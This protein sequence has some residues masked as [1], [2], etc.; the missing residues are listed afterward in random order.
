MSSINLTSDLSDLIIVANAGNSSFIVETGTIPALFVNSNTNIGINTVT[1][2]AQLEVANASGSCLRL[3]HK[4]LTGAHADMSISNSG[5]L[6]IAP[7]TTGSK[8]SITKSLDITNHNGSTTGL[9][10]GGVLLSATAEQI[11]AVNS[12][13]GTA[14][15]SKVV[16]LDSST[17]IAGINSLS[18][19]S[20]GGT[21]TTATQPNITS[22]GT[23]ASLT[24]SGGVSASTLT[25]TLQTSAQP[26]ITSIGTLSSL[27][28]SGSV[29]AS[30][31]TGT[32][33]TGAQPNIT[34]LGDLSSLT[35][36]GA[37]VD[38][39]FAF[40]SGSVAG[41]ASENHVLVIDAD[42][43][44]T[45]IGAL[46]ATSLT[47]TL[48]TAA[49]PHA[50]SL[51][52]LSSLTVSGGITASSL[53]GSIQTAAQP[54]ITSLGDLVSLT[55]A[56]SSVSPE[57]SYLAGVTPGTAGP[58]KVVVLDGDKSIS[59]L[60]TL[61]ATTL[62][63]TI[64]TAA[65]PNI[66]SLG[67]LSQIHIAGSTIG[68]E[69]S[70]LAGVVA[71]TAEA[72]KV[73]VLNSGGSI[74]GITSLTSTNIYGTIQT[75]DQSSVTKV[76]TLTSLTVNG[77]TSITATA[78]SSSAGTGALTITGGVGIAKKLYVGDAIYGTLATAAQT[79]VT[80][81]GTL[82]GL[83]VSG[84]IAVT[85]NITVNGNAVTTQGTIVFPEYVTDITAGTA[86]NLKALVLNSAGSVSGINALS[87]TSLTGTLQ[88]AAQP[89]ITSVGTLTSLAVT[90]GITAS[91]ITGTLSTAAQT[92]I[93]SVGTLGSLAVTG[94]ITA[95]SVSATT[96]SGTLD[97]AAQPNI[98]SVGLLS[99]LTVSGGVTASTLTGTIATASQP[100]VTTIGTLTSLAVTGAGSVGGAFTLSNSTDSTSSTT[101]A[102]RCAG[103]AY[104]GGASVFNSSAAIAGTVS[105]SSTAA[106]TSASTG[107]LQCAGG[108]YFG[109][110]CYMNDK[111]ATNGWIGVGTSS[112]TAP[113]HVSS[114]LSTAVSPSANTTLINS[115]GSVSYMGYNPDV[116]NLSAK[117][118]GSVLVMDLVY[119]ASDVR[120]KRDIDS[121]SSTFAK[122]LITSANPVKYRFKDTEGETKFAYGFIAQDLMHGKYY[123]F[124]N[125]NDHVGT[126]EMI[127]DT[128]LISP[129]DMVFNV[130]YNNFISVLTKAQKDTY[131]SVDE[132]KTENAELKSRVSALEETIA[133]LK[134]KLD[135][136]LIK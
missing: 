28:V 62:T 98:T 15:A 57:I 9:K 72:S 41:S 86:A 5:D 10:L 93:T 84:D 87:A 34:S 101:G 99:S 12:T 29:S 88:T 40:L 89:N 130:N 118:D 94:A 133:D 14:E 132:L 125:L 38:S 13:P 63:G 66:T 65:Q 44:I 3:S 85:G 131:E 39:E 111:L 64:H 31:L 114:K 129:K 8:V 35:V 24:V 127:D 104:F 25:G 18:A 97:T 45:G 77:A 69:A 49:Q 71:G 112:P 7:Y 51:G 108:A 2:S 81:L 124:V 103:G 107:A 46:S 113:L 16:I 32:L 120:I 110:A 21:L 73:L 122:E 27:T 47:G 82:S 121:V 54:N 79:N 119:I 128:G 50:T 70:Y 68:S 83:T 109:A 36:A 37:A 75:A 95:G 92:S 58:T 106:S 55:V 100:N 1:P 19:T 4:G 56:G 26:N 76:G 136:L 43:A 42:K 20:L 134:N 30:S 115:A 22:L 60:D 17:S 126:E 74:T 102:L 53:T 59:G 135:W 48:M 52:T 123:D 11:N 6:T 67:S 23:L 80:S 91:T 96:L 33:Q 105:L 61:S 90:G 78:D 117:F 116:N